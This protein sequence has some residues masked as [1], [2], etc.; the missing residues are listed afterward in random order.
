L[1]KAGKMPGSG[2]RSVK[3]NVQ[4]LKA[5]GGVKIVTSEKNKGDD[6]EAIMKGLSVRKDSHKILAP[7]EE[8]LFLG[9]WWT[10]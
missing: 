9:A 3:T 8:H 6:T 2:K 1:L 5:Q 10:R 7:R 4:T